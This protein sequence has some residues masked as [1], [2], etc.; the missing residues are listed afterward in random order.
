MQALDDIAALA[1][2][3][4]ALLGVRGQNPARGTGGLGE[5]QPL[6]RPHPSDPDLPQGIAPRIAFRTEIDHTLRPSRFPGKRPD[7]FVVQRSAFTSAS[8]PRRTSSSD[9][10]PS[11]R[12][13]NSPARARNP[14]PI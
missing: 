14:E 10:G 5:P 8:N 3:A 12:V 9:R 7:E 13:T 2:R 11:S 1:K 4:Q 6:K